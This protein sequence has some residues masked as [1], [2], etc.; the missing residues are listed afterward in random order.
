MLIQPAVLCSSQRSASPAASSASQALPVE[1]PAP[2]STL[3]SGLA[4]VV[5]GTAPLLIQESR[6][7]EIKMEAETQ[8]EEDERR[9]D[10]RVPSLP[11]ASST[12]DSNIVADEPASKVARPTFQSKRD[13]LLALPLHLHQRRK[14]EHHWD[15]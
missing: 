1:V 9:H 12:T 8:D 10:E 3:T 15:A 2:S 6:D 13:L 4:V 7:V 11:L 5:A 14:L